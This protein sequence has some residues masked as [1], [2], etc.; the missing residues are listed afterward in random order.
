MAK[1]FTAILLVLAA[2][3]LAAGG[4]GGVAGPRMHRAPPPTQPEAARRPVEPPRD[5]LPVPPLTYRNSNALVK[6]Y[7]PRLEVQASTAWPGY[8]AHLAIDGEVT[9]SWF[10]AHGDSAAQGKAPFIELRFPVA[11]PVRRVTVV[12]NRDP[13]W[14]HGYSVLA[15][16]LELFDAQGRVLLAQEQPAAADGRDFEFTIPR[17]LRAQRLR[18]TSIRDEGAV[19]P[20]GDVAVAEL[21]VE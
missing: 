12:G 20:Y 15:G 9:T 4:D 18:F 1:T 16:R 17:K 8:E 7:Q 2:V 5:P 11:V 21:Q 13:S 19:N 3:A 6:E 14:P 10:S